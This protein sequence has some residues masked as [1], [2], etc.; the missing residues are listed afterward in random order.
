[1][2]YDLAILGG[3]PAGVA[4][5]VYA[6]RKRMQSIIIAK[7]FGGQSKVSLDVQNWIGTPHISGTDLAR[8]LK[9]H[10]DTYA[11]G[12]L[13]IKEGQK[14]SNIEQI[15]DGFRIETENGE[16][17]DAQTVL[18]ATG[19]RRRK[20]DVPG[21]E[22]F[23]GKGIVYCASCDAPLFKGKDVVVIGGGNAGFET[24]SQLTEYANTV[25]L[26]EHGGAF[27]AD[28]ITVEKVL[29]NDKVTAITEAEVT[30]V[31]GD[32]F[33]N[34]IAYKDLKTD[35]EKEIATGG[36]FVEI[37]QI[38]NTDFAK[39]LLERDDYNHIKIDP[40]TQQTTQP[41]I[42]AAGDCTD[43]L[44]HQNNIAAGDAVRA[45]EDIYVN[46]KTR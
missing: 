6:A 32:K 33:V 12:A 29:R 9:Q 36:V 5:G 30:A 7:D 21:A 18:I 13:A 10:L 15:S 19:S 23:D 42:W 46:L 26:L 16:M 22:E 20:L 27:K 2:K 25:T 40:K 3:G 35:E 28:S 43:V 31:R 45:I 39:E 24:A 17:Y 11:E 8:T 37:G 38:P 44:Y 4:A 1:M 34:A 14:I 41:G